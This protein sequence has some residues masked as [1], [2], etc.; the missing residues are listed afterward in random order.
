ME[1][2]IGYKQ[3]LHPYRL[4]SGSWERTIKL[5]NLA[6]GKV[7]NTLEGHYERIL[8]VAIAADNKTIVSGSGDKTIR[9]WQSEL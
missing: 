6:T 2:A 4:I 1:L 7:I 8:S 5:W 9:V 3:I